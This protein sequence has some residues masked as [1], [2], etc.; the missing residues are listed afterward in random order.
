[1]AVPWTLDA[2]GGSLPPVGS[3]GPQPVASVKSSGDGL[4]LARGRKGRTA[5]AQTKNVLGHPLMFGNK[6]IGA[7]L[8]RT[9]RIS[10]NT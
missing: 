1:M 8:P 10:H 5:I 4:R 2:E 3:T 6:F 9:L 7:H